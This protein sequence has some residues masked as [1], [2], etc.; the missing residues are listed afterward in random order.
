MRKEV[1]PKEIAKMI[2][3]FPRERGLTLSV[4]ECD[5]LAKEINNTYIK[6]WDET[7]KYCEKCAKMYGNYGEDIIIVIAGN[8][9]QFRRFQY[10]LSPSDDNDYIYASD[11][12]KI[13]GTRAR[14]IIEIGT[15]YERKDYHEIKREALSQITN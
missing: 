6:K 15:A 1:T 8:L 5:F 11:P 2:H 3:S 9:E 13:R 7:Q 10:D 12:L 4:M 14:A